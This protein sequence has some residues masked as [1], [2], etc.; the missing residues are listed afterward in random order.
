MLQKVQMD[1]N[2]EIAVPGFAPK[3]SATPGSR[4]LTRTLGRKKTKLFRR[5]KN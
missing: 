5:S 2:S 3:L 1:D 4:L